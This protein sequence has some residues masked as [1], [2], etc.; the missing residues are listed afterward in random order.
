MA[1]L[2]NLTPKFFLNPIESLIKVSTTLSVPCRYASKKTAGAGNKN[3]GN[4]RAKHR[5]WKRQDGAI[6]TAGTILATQNK[7]RWH[8]GLN[9]GF[10]KNG[11]LHALVSG[12]VVVTCEKIDPNWDHTWIQRNYGEERKNQV[13]YKKHWNVIPEPQH[14]TFKLLDKI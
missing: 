11:T 13:I 2:R 7:T 4:A 6:V 8:P 12:K 3:A 10:G 1:T 14:R 5:G 9:V